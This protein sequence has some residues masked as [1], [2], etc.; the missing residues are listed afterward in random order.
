MRTVGCRGITVLTQ[1]TEEALHVSHLST[2]VIFPFILTDVTVRTR[3]PRT[4]VTKV[5]TDQVAT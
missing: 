4:A 3:P 1:T 5:S 2:I